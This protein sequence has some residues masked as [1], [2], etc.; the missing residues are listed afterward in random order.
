MPKK[1][2]ELAPIAI[3]N[4]TR[5]GLHAVGGVSGLQIQIN[6]NGAKS[7]ILRTTI[8]QKRRDIGLG[9]YPDV[10]LSQ[11]REK[12]R[13]MKDLIRQGVDPV[14]ARKDARSA[15]IATQQKE[16]TFE[17]AAKEYMAAK[18]AEWKNAKHCAQWESTLKTYAYPVI[19]RMQVKDIELSHVMKILEPIWHEKTETAKRL[20]GRIENVLDWSTVRKYREGENPARWKGWLDTILPKPSKVAK[21]S[22]FTALPHCQIGQFMKDLQSREGVARFALEFLILTA[23]RSGEIRGMVWDEIDLD[24]KVWTIPATRMKAGKEHKIPLCDKAV[25]ILQS[26]PRHE[27]CDFVFPSARNGQIS[28][29]TMGAVIK[30]MDYKVTVHGFRSTFRDWAAERTNYPRE[31]AEQAL[32]HSIGAVERAYRRSDLLEKRRRMMQEWERYCY[33]VQGDAQIVPLHKAGV[34]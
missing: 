7:W 32:A 10:T 16:I 25:Q 34:E 30:R 33:T 29:M 22:N 11:A 9:G 26:M 13:E 5:K 18:G 12:A 2:P 4:L 1:V 14:Q 17:K 6:D 28:D 20:R 23:A 24:A 19:G 3:K 15:L 27:G 31:I 8:G 21:K